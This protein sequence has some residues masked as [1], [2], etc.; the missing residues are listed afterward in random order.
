VRQIDVAIIGGSLAGAACARE[1]ASMGVETVAFE[2]GAMPREKVCGGF[3][4]PG[5]VKSLDRLGLLGAVRAAGARVAHRARVSAPAGEVRFDLPQSGLGIS[6]RTLDAVV[7]NGAPIERGNVTEVRTV[8]NGFEL[9][10]EGSVIRSRVVIDAAGKLSRFTPHAAEAE[11]GVQFYD[12][13]F[14][15][16]G[17]LSFWF[18]NDGYGGAVNVEGD[19][20]NCCFL[21]RK[22]ALDRYRSKPRCHVTGPLAYRATNS[23]WIAIGDAAGMIDPFCGEGMRHALDSARIAADAVARGLRD[24]R[25]YED[26]RN[27]YRTDWRSRWS[28]KRA[29]ARCLRFA[30]RHPEPFRRVL[31][32]QN[33]WI[34]QRSIERLW[35]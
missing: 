20:T 12:D 15:E 33:P 9:D 34:F 35:A 10:V 1:L 8:S 5:A 4:S 27:S 28:G 31:G 17:T 21:I 16:E 25:P 30:A 3:L 19:Q 26:I 13:G 29:L 7:A 32:V 23:P 2:R 22:S 11:F 14:A 6:R 24:G 18:F